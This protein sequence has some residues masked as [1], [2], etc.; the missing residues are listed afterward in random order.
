MEH[1]DPLRPTPIQSARISQFAELPSR[2]ADLLLLGDSLTEQ[3]LWSEWFPELSVLNRGV[4]GDTVEG[5]L[6]RFAERPDRAEAVSLLI[7]TN[8]LSRGT[9]P[10]TLADSFRRLV[11]RLRGELPDAR[12]IVTS[13][14][15]RSVDLRD[16]IRRLNDDSRDVAAGHGAQWL[17]LWPAL[18]DEHGAL[19]ERFTSDGL[20][21]TGAAYRVWALALGRLLGAETGS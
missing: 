11:E 17:D 20:H 5:L 18:A 19:P 10:I 21:F 12:L 4:G 2:H 13:V 14:P 8:D 1:P 6:R 9:D 7:G 15:P 3:G 16:R